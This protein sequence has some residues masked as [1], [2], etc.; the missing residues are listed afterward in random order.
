MAFARAGLGEPH[1]VRDGVGG[2]ERRHDALRG[3]ER[4]EAL[5]RLL[6]RHRHEIESARVAVVAARARRPVVE[7]AEIE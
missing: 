5:E 2:L 7:P 3:R 4:L 6:V 1:R